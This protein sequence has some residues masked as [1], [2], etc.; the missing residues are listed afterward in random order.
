M[1][2]KTADQLA[3]PRRKM[4]PVGGGAGT[5][6]IPPGWNC[7]SIRR[8][9]NASEM[10]TER[11]SL[12]QPHRRRQLTTHVLYYRVNKRDYYEASCCRHCR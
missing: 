11:Q 10:P 1:S 6:E 9:R 7:A 4:R 2:T 5:H 12:S 8:A 3:Q